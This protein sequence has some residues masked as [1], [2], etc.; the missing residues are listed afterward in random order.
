MEEKMAN[1]NKVQLTGFLGYD[2]KVIDKDGKIFVTLSI[3]TTDSYLVKEGGE[4]KWE[5]KETVWHNVLAFSEAL[6]KQVATLKKGDKVELI[7]SISYKPFKDE[8]GVSRLNAV[9][10]GSQIKK[11]EYGKHTEAVVKETAKKM[12]SRG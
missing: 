7:G 8:N 10:I 5:D 3:A 12:R 11:L 9:I 2:P 4:M 6:R 1:N